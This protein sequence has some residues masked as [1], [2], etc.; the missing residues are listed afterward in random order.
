MIIL[1]AFFL[2]HTAEPVDIP[3]QDKVDIFLPRFEFEYK[4]DV[5]KP[6]AM[7]G[8]ALPDIYQ[9]FRYNQQTA[10]DNALEVFRETEAEYENIFH[11]SYGAVEQYKCDDAELILVTSGTVSSTARVV[12]DELRDKGKKVGLLKMKLF[13][14]FPYEIC[15]NI[16]GGVPKVAVI[17][18]NIC[19]GFGGIWAQ[20][21]MASLYSL[22][23][24][25]RPLIYPCITG[26]GGRDITP[27]T[28][29]KVV[30][31]AQAEGS[32]SQKIY[33]ID[34]KE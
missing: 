15:R 9:E 32:P 14:P 2:S 19:P 4:L 6:H 13:R 30:E 18:R 26:L 20:E 22:P 5:D 28:I 10:F 17:D 29:Q 34:L 12:I 31:T 23:E 1:D 25:K 33:W 11:R 21:I 8:A 7:F 3:D 24:S 27:D 16:L